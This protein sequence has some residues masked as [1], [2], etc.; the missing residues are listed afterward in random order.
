MNTVTAITPSD[1]YHAPLDRSRR[2]Y[3]HIRVLRW[4]FKRDGE[5]A[6]VCELALTG[7]DREY[8]ITRPRGVESDRAA[9][10]AIRRCA[11]GVS[12][13]MR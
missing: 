9:G 6:V 10:R 4:T 12:N 8:E 3:R 7:E 2:N 13:G 1:A 5:D 11:D